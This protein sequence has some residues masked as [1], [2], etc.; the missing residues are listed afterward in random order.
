LAAASTLQEGP[1]RTHGLVALGAL[2]D[3]DADA[4]V[5]RPLAVE[6]GCL[7]QQRL[8]HAAKDGHIEFCGVGEMLEHGA[9]RDAGELGDVAHDRRDFPVLR[10]R[11]CRGDDGFARAGH[12]VT[13]SGML[14]GRLRFSRL[15]YIHCLYP[16]ERSLLTR[17][18]A[19][20]VR[21]VTRFRPR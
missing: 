9:R 1:H 16:C 5:E 15:H 18:L 21:A 8:H 10:E 14:G 17:S 11:E 20:C 7:A 2:V 13:A 6:L 12:A 19:H 3:D 4:L